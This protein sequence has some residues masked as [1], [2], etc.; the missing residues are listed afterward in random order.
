MDIK[1]KQ[2]SEVLKKMSSLCWSRFNLNRICDLHDMGA[3]EF[4]DNLPYILLQVF[5]EGLLGY[6]NIAGL[7]TGSIPVS[8]TEFTETCSI[9]KE[10]ASFKISELPD[11]IHSDHSV[12]KQKNPEKLLYVRLAGHCNISIQL[13]NQL[14]IYY[15][16]MMQRPMNKD[17]DM[18]LQN[19]LDT[20]IMMIENTDC[21]I[22]FNER[23]RE[24]FKLRIGKIF[25]HYKR[26][27]RHNFGSTGHV[28]FHNQIVYNLRDAVAEEAGGKER[29][30]EDDWVAFFHR[31][32]INQLEF[33]RVCGR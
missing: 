9:I 27:F 21:L 6:W 16:H 1:E 24:S 28:L 11:N 13:E 3:T 5:Y 19:V 17:F 10:I 29:Q 15:Q 23:A 26:V 31:F 4:N 2:K 22:N 18:L 14:G 8:L 12:I 32:F 20:E 33:E 25:N 30:T 7:W